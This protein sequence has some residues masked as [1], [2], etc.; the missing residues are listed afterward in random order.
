MAIRNLVIQCLSEDDQAAADAVLKKRGPVTRSG[1][2]VYGAGDDSDIEVLEEKG[3]VVEEVAAQPNLSWLEPSQQDADAAG[4][5]LS[6]V[7]EE[8]A[9]PSPIREAAVGAENVYMI[10]LKGPIRPDWKEKLDALGIELG[11]YV[12]EYAYKAK[13]SDEQKSQVEDLSFVVR[14]VLYSAVHTLRRLTAIEKIREAV[15]VEEEGGEPERP[16]M[17][18]MAPGFGEAPKVTYEVRCHEVED[19]PVVAAA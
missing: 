2:Y 10:Q 16:P 19:I 18:G 6:A 12:P 17:L 3:L 4:E 5:F 11:S 8:F 9:P 1:M 15:G 7:D 13:L 14:V